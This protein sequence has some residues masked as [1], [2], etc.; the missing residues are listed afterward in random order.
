MNNVIITILSYSVISSVNYSQ[1]IFHDDFFKYGL[2]EEDE[3][4]TFFTYM[5]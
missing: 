2:N 5:L 1:G 4:S 3:L